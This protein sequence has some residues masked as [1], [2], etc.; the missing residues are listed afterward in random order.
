VTRQVL[1]SEAA[2]R[3]YA[4]LPKSLRTRLYRALSE[5]ASTGRGDIKRLHGTR[6]REDLYRLRVGDY[7]IILAVSTEEVRVT[8]IIHR[9][10]GYA[11]L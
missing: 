3:A 6:G 8:R 5:F 10:K 1:L 11:W 2:N 4:G 7:R 9:S